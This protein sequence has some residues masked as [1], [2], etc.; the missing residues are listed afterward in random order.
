MWRPE[1]ARG[2]LCSPGVT[3]SKMCTAFA[4]P[5]LRLLL[6]AYCP[7]AIM[8]VVLTFACHSCKR[9]ACSA[10][11]SSFPLFLFVFPCDLL[12][13]YSRYPGIYQLLLPIG[14]GPVNAA[15][16][17]PLAALHSIQTNTRPALILVFLLRAQQEDISAAQA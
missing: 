17:G 7:A 5:P 4:F 1:E 15:S 16:A 11:F 14:Q 3:Y 6:P 8:A 13:V 12:D 9:G 2:F 10:F